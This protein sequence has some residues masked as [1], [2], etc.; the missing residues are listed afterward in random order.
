MYIFA[1]LLLV[2]SFLC[3]IFCAGAAAVQLWQKQTD[4]L[5]LVE[6]GSYVTTGLMTLS[7]FILLAAF[8][9]NDFAVEYVARYSDRYLPLFYRITAF[10]AGQEGS[11]L[12]WGWSVAIFG[13]FFLTSKTY[14]KLTAETKL[15]FWMFFLAIIAFFLLLIT[16]WSNP[17]ITFNRSVQDGNGLNP[18]LQNPGMIFHPPL[19][20][21][22]YGGFV[23]PGCLALAQT[24]SNKRGEEGLWSTVC[25]P[26]TILAWLLLS[27]GIILGAWWAYMELG[28][29]GYWAWDPVENA[30]LI[31]WLIATAFLHTSVIEARRG[32]LQRF[33]VFLMGLT[34]IS[35]FFATYIVRSGIIDSV[36]G[37]PD[38]G[39]AIPLMSFVI[40]STVISF[41]VAFMGNFRSPALASPAS[42]E[43]MLM[44][45][46]VILLTTGVIVLTATLWPVLSKSAAQVIA[47]F[48]SNAKIVSTGLDASFYNRVCLPLL[49]LLVLLLVFCPWVSWGGGF[50]NAVIA[51]VLAIIFVLGLPVFLII[52]EGPSGLGLGEKLSAIMSAGPR[53]V[54]AQIAASA[55]LAV[56]VSLAALFIT[57][58][59][60]LKSHVTVAAHGVHLGVAII[61]LGIAFSGPYQLEGSYALKLGESAKL[62]AYEFTLDE[63]ATGAGSGYEF[64]EAT[65]KTGKNGGEIGQMKPQRRHYEKYPQQAFMEASTISGLGNELYASLLRMDQRKGTAEVHVSVNPLVNWIW[66]GGV[67]LCL[68]PLVGLFGVRKR[69]SD[70]A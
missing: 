53:H 17:F 65:L 70:A 56:I 26:F 32:K 5:G 30:S 59:A 68:F 12:F 54:T 10:W 22:G 64:L 7:S 67:V 61:A 60:L 23:I 36:H 29:G 41:L 55:A 34:T 58:T 49:A 16:G 69:E 62:G 63:V 33:N 11:L 27:A 2:A 38:G 43:G 15:W 28:W 39:V 9:N 14:E 40:F 8:V 13:V 35:A 31:P 46:A 19:L 6:K 3:A 21:L 20:F 4:T 25:R 45:V 18:L 57:N 50:R 52:M 1:F 48:S 24:L 42:R 66:I 51:T 44:G 37:F 47:I